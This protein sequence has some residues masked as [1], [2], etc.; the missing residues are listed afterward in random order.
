MN[1]WRKALV[2][3]L[4][5]LGAERALP[6]YNV[7]DVMGLAKA[8]LEACVRFLAQDFWPDGIRVDGISTAD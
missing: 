5:Y 8:S 6:F 2:L 1:A 3:T 4:S 7:M